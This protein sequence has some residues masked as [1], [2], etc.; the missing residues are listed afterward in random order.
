MGFSYTLLVKLTV[1]K[2]NIMCLKCRQESIIV[3]NRVVI[4]ISGDNSFVNIAMKWDEM[5]A[6]TF[7][8]YMFNIYMFTILIIKI[9]SAW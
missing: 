4:F 3:F 1:D 2:Y 8:R 5:N 7:L 9:N 6:L